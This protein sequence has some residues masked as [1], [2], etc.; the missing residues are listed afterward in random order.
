MHSNVSI[1]SHRSQLDF[2]EEVVIENNRDDRVLMQQC[3]SSSI[4]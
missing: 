1:V 4:N 3:Q 2:I